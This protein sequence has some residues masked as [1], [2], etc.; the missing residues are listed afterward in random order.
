MQLI[1]S[2]DT[3][4]NG[5]AILYGGFIYLNRLK[6]ASERCIFLNLTT[7]GKQKRSEGG[8]EHYSPELI[9]CGGSYA[10]QPSCKLEDFSLYATD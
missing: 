5:Y 10:L 3:P 4:Q 7:L 2:F 8:F 9:Y 6:T 1:T